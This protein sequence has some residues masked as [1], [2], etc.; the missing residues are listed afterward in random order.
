L[1]FLSIAAKRGFSVESYRDAAEGVMTRNEAGKLWVSSVTLRPQVSYQGR[2]PTSEEEHALHH[3][4][5]E[6][7][8]IAN[9]VKTR[10]SVEPVR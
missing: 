7:C 4:A 10:V 3:A 8:F 2:A 6:E 9:S 5:H 1:W